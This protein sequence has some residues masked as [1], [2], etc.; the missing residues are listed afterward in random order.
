MRKSTY[1]RRA[2]SN[3]AEPPADESASTAKRAS[4]CAAAA[5]SFSRAS[6]VFGSAPFSSML[7]CVET[8]NRYCARPSWISRATRALLGDGAAELGE[9]DRPPDAHEQDAVGEQAQ[10]VALR[11]VAAREQRRE[12]VVELREERE[13]RAEAE[14]AVEVVAARAEAKPEE[15][16]K[17]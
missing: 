4:C 11:D 3:G 17:R 12:D 14:P 6:V 7:A 2:E 10:E 1:R 13:G 5:A 9:A 15:V 8:A 16:L